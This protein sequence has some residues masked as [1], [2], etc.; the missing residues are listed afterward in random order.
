MFDQEFKELR[1]TDDRAGN[2]GRPDQL[3][4]R[5]PRAKI[6]ALGKA[7]GADDRQR[8]VVSQASRRFRGGYDWTSRR[9]SK[10]GCL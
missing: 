8:N 7:V 4:L 6:T 10:Q 1:R 9:I 3:F 5:D 2:L